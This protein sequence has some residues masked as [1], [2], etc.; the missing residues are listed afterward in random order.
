M[1]RVAMLQAY[2]L[3]GS[4]RLIHGAEILGD[5]MGYGAVLVSLLV[6]RDTHRAPMSVMSVA[7]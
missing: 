5:S 6:P 3:P 1:G 7:A 4:M 2:W